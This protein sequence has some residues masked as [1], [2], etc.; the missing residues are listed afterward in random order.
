MKYQILKQNLKKDGVRK[1][2]QYTKQELNVGISI[3][4]ICNNNKDSYM[5]G[6][7]QL[8]S[9]ARAKAIL[10]KY[11]QLNLFLDKAQLHFTQQGKLLYI[12]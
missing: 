6:L 9:E 10:K 2:W 12:L 11:Y 5:L 7:T 3:T 8:S 4:T 1:S